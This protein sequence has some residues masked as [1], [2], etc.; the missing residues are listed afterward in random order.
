M[1]LKQ[2]EIIALIGKNGAGKLSICKFLRSEFL[3]SSIGKVQI[4][5]QLQFSFVR[6]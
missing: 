5:L 6:Q 4:A 3:D 1:N 2:A